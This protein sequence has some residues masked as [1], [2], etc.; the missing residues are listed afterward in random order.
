MEIQK[1]KIIENS[2]TT[3]TLSDKITLIANGISPDFIGDNPKTME[4][5]RISPDPMFHFD[6]VKEKAELELLELLKKFNNEIAKDYFKE[7]EVLGYSNAD[8]ILE[9]I[10]AVYSKL[11]RLRSYGVKAKIVE[12]HGAGKLDYEVLKKQKPNLII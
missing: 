9:A 1:T 3:E 10:E 7:L 4:E 2:N 6:D 5:G 11:N 8:A 12:N